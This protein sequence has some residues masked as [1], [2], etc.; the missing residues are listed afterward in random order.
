MTCVC[1]WPTECQTIAWKEGHKRECMVPGAIKHMADRDV[2]GF[3]LELH[4]HQTEEERKY[5]SKDL[6]SNLM[7]KHAK[8]CKRL[9]VLERTRDWVT[10][11]K[12]ESKCIEIATQLRVSAPEHAGA[13]YASLG[14]CFHN[15][16][17][18]RK[19][20]LMHEE[21]LAVRESDGDRLG[22]GNAYNNLGNCY[23]S[24][25]EYDKAIALYG[26][27]LKIACE[28]GDCVGVGGACGNIGNCY[29]CMGEYPAAT[30]L[31]QKSRE[32]ARRE[33]DKVEEGRAESNLGH[34]LTILNLYRAAYECFLEYWEISMD[35]ELPRF[36]EATTA[37]LQIG[38]VLVKHLRACG[39]RR[40]AGIL[41]Y[42]ESETRHQKDIAD[43]VSASFSKLENQPSANIMAALRGYD[44]KYNRN[45]APRT[46]GTDQPH[47]KPHDSTSA[48]AQSRTNEEGGEGSGMDWHEKLAVA[49]NAL[50]A[51]VEAL[52]AESALVDEL[53]DKLSRSKR[54]DDSTSSNAQP[55]GTTSATARPDYSMIGV[56]QADASISAPTDG[57][58]SD[59]ASPD[60]S[61]SGT[62]QLRDKPEGSAQ[63]AVPS[64]L[65]RSKKTPPGTAQP[66]KQ[67]MWG[68]L[69]PYEEKLYQQ[70]RDPTRP[71]D[72]VK[73]LEEAQYWIFI[74]MQ[75][76]FLD[77]QLQLAH[78]AF[79][80]GEQDQALEH[81]TKYLISCSESARTLCRGCWQ[82]RGD[83]QLL[84][85]G[86][87]ACC[88]DARL[89]LFAS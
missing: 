8:F 10:L 15:T 57:S 25:G 55:D 63:K 60:D 71:F 54:T 30:W 47:D 16:G 6:F 2:M 49:N 77:V 13:I 50:D 76:G 87:T 33:G 19:A 70:A 51:K 65:S 18:Y 67:N 41:N 24:I 11:S 72:P 79:E 31:F 20:A 52:L 68:N 37:A 21:C 1:L 3:G 32:I 80:E 35:Q 14:N 48:T 45:A 74:A 42:V 5:N 64:G 58:A 75:G 38:S 53:V 27:H 56:A 7:P 73:K 85:C 12:L 17:Q 26:K 9:Q 44:M 86:G 66:D 89:R 34:V 40:R 62:A 81:F 69:L 29:E 83:V 61:T 22:V 23:L 28:A 39:R 84:T 36:R 43:Q 78:I 46:S 4:A 82:R 59:A 88:A